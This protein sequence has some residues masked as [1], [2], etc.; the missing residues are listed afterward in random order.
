MRSKTALRAAR[1]TIRRGRGRTGQSARP[2]CPQIQFVVDCEALE[3]IRVLDLQFR[4]QAAPDASGRT[5]RSGHRLRPA[6]WACPRSG[7]LYSFCSRTTP[8]ASSMEERCA[9]FTQAPIRVACHKTWLVQALQQRREHGKVCEFVGQIAVRAMRSG[10]CRRT[11]SSRYRLSR[12]KASA[13]QIGDLRYDRKTPPAAPRRLRSRCRRRREVK[14]RRS[15]QHQRRRKQPAAAFCQFLPACRIL[16]LLDCRYF[17]TSGLQE[18]TKQRA[19]RAE[20]HRFRMKNH[21]FVG[22]H[23]PPCVLHLWNLVLEDN[24][25]L[26]DVTIFLKAF[27]SS[28]F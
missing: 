16:Q 13:V 6:R 2:C 8:A 18:K 23:F 22:I 28:E 25:F 17:I 11:S 1:R 20:P 26:Y 7:N 15:S 5:G 27:N 10:L 4:A 24:V 12:V 21:S 3:D 14:P 19:H 9:L